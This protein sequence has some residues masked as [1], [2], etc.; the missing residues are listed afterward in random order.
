MPRAI[1][2]TSSQHTH[3]NASNNRS[4]NQF[5]DTDDRVALVESVSS[6]QSKTRR[7]KKTL[8]IYDAYSNSKRR[9]ILATVS[10]VAGLLPFCDTIYLPVLGLI[11]KDLDTTELLVNISVSIYLFMNGLGALFW[12]PLSDRYGRK[13]L[14][15]VSLVIFVASS[16]VCIFAPNISVLLVFRAIQGATVAV[17]L[18]SGQGVIADIYPADRRGWATGIFFVPLLVGPVIGPLIGGALSARFGWRST[19]VLLSIL[20]FIITV[21]VL[22]V[23]PETQHYMFKKQFEQRHKRTTIVCEGEIQKQSFRKPWI[24][25][26]F[27]INKS[28]APYAIVATVTFAGLFISLTLFGGYLSKKPYEKDETIIGVLFVP[29]GFAMLVGSILGGWLSD[30]AGVYFTPALPEGRLVPAI[31]FSSLTPIGLLIYGWGFHY[32]LHLSMSIIGQIILGFGQSVHQPGVFAYLTAKKPKDAA[33]VSAANSMLNFCG[34]AVGVTIAAPL[35]EA[36]GIGGFF[37]LISGINVVAILFAGVLVYRI[38]RSSRS[39]QNDA[40]NQSENQAMS[41]FRISG[42]HNTVNSTDLF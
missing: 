36:M 15:L 8:S 16:V 42:E 4:P 32:Q 30:K 38:V 23:L 20:S 10:L 31:I 37:C 12:G 3:S 7:R 14:L 1:H 6:S 35:E 11:E 2:P 27:L 18:V 22:F 17:T 33:A 9:V 19:F 5:N 41:V 29:A 28:I 39:R 25:L 13:R 21:I 26:Q 40:D 34:A 24:P